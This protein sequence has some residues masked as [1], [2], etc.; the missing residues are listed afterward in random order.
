MKFREL[1]ED[2]RELVRRLLGQKLADQ[3]PTIKGL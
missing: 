3:G 1:G 2:E